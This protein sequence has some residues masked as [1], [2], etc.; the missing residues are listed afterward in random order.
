MLF[1][2]HTRRKL[3]IRAKHFFFKRGLLAIR[4]E[5]V[6]SALS[7]QANK[8]HDSSDTYCTKNTIEIPWKKNI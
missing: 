4:M 8:I 3:Q 1:F 7:P 5:E 2:L 6:S